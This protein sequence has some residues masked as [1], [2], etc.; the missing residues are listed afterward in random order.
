MGVSQLKQEFILVL[1]DLENGISMVHDDTSTIVI[2]V[3]SSRLSGTD[4]KHRAKFHVS[5]EFSH[6]GGGIGLHR[7][8]DS[9]LGE[10]TIVEIGKSQRNL[11]STDVGVVSVKLSV[12]FLD[13]SDPDFISIHSS[14]GVKGCVLEV[15]WQEVVN[16]DLFDLTIL[17]EFE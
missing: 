6:E 4:T 7:S 15:D 9:S 1:F 3:S 13:N 10:S 14:L 12:T 2:L 8:E 5:L 17:S 16:N 11:T